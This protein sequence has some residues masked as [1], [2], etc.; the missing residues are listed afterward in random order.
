MV[1]ILTILASCSYSRH[2][3]EKISNLAQGSAYHVTYKGSNPEKIKKGVDSIMSAVDNSIS[4]YNPL[5]VITKIN[6]NKDMKTDSIFNDLF[7]ISEKLYYETDGCFD[8]SSGPLFNFWGFGARTDSLFMKDSEEERRDTIR[9]IMKLTGIDGY[10]L[11]DGKLEKPHSASEINFN[12]IAQGYTCDIVGKYLEKNG[13]T[14]YLIEVGG[15]ILCKGLNRNG[16]EWSIGIDR[17]VD[18]NLLA[19]S[20]I[21]EIISVSG[22]GI[23]TSGNYR[24]YIIENG[25]KYS[26]TINPKTG[27]PVK[28][29]LLS[30]T[31]I[32]D[33][34][35][36][37]DA[38][39][40]YFMVIGVE[41]AK[42]ILSERTDLE[43]YLIYGD[44][45]SPQGTEVYY[46]KGLKIRTMI[47]NN[48]DGSK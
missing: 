2:S 38:Y 7:R 40:T 30:A 29:N 3:Y 20:D 42:E 12:A 8:V 44:P 22:K 41:K 15:E 27:Y 34:A 18:G 21:Q 11:H 32:A 47:K 5:S 26:H 9:Q 4:L 10:R 17:P 23:V 39:A 48:T 46:S 43:G 45:E 33:D 14:D 35:T 36:T 6:N 16:E 24:K 37:A 31:V 25:T 13:I 28:H 19:G 1:T